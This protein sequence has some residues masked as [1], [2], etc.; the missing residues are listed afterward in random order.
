MF[1]LVVTIL[2]VEEQS[3][4]VGGV[5]LLVDLFERPVFVAEQTPDGVG[6]NVVLKESFAV[7]R[8]VLDRLGR[9]FLVQLV[10]TMR[11]LAF[12][13]VAASSFLNPV[14]THLGF[15]LDLSFSLGS[16]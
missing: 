12:L 9:R 11:E 13:V 7:L 10:R 14:F 1:L 3:T 15:I 2:K 6:T 5:V 8:A 16:G 4:E